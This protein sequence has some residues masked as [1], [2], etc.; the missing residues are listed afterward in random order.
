MVS[1]FTDGDVTLM[2]V[3]PKVAFQDGA[4]AATVYVR[5]TTEVVYEGIP[6]PERKPSAGL[7]VEVWLAKGS[8]ED[9]ARVV[10]R[11]GPAPPSPPG[12][13]YETRVTLEAESFSLENAE[14]V[15]RPA[16]GGG[17]AILFGTR[18]GRARINASLRKGVYGV[19]VHLE[20][21]G[22]EHDAV[23]FR[24][25]RQSYRFYQ[26]QR[27][28]FAPGKVWGAREALIDI[29]RTGDHEVTLEKIE[30]DVAVDRVVLSRLE[31]GA[32][33]DGPF[34]P[35]GEGFLRDWLVLAPI[36]AEEGTAGAPEVDREALPGEGE[37]RPFEGEA[38]RVRGRRLVWR[39]VRTRGPQL[40]LRDFA[41]SQN[42]PAEDVVGY[43][44][45]SVW[46]ERERTRLELRMGSNDQARVW[47]N[48]IPLLAH[49]RTRTL[50]PDASVARGV[51]LRKG[52]NLVVFKIVN[53]KN[54]WGGCLRFILA[55]GRPLTGVRVGPPE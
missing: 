55:T 44:V 21:R 10:F 42:A 47:L 6:R 32:V 40:D 54:D 15:D 25:D 16:A 17:R 36:P 53:E 20:G 19:E 8:E 9:A 11:R 12:R 50:V 13:K 30:S 7:Y 43:A 34:Q 27:G 28:R 35:D 37:L 39:R 5:E 33:T 1:A 48:G 18:D 45:C 49:H 51:T 46:C 24:V 38:V 3:A 41:L 31:P 14:V 29:P 26:D 52:E 4:T 22:E 23:F 2:T